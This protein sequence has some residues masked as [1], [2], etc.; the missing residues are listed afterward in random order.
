VEL[1]LRYC[2][3]CGSRTLLKII[4]C[5]LCYFDLFS[6]ASN[7]STK[8]T[9]GSQKV[10]GMVVLQC[11]GR[12]YGNACLIAFKVRP[13]RTHTLAPSILPLL[14]APAEGFFW[15]LPEFGRRVRFD[16]LHGCET[17]PLEAHFQGTEQPKVI[18]SEIRRVR[19]R[20]DDTTSDVWLGESS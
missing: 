9:I 3:F 1:C 10:P 20:G 6:H 2:E 14:E 8:N 4:F 7:Y 17:S 5:Y 16:V 15:N 18:G 12:T 19:W 13:L 11:N